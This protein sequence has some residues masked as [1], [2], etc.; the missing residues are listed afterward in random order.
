MQ[1]PGREALLLVGDDGQPQPG[2][3][4]FAQRSLGAGVGA[5]GVGFVVL[6]RA[7]VVEEA[8]DDRRLQ[9]GGQLAPLRCCRARDQRRRA[10]ADHAPHLLAADGWPALFGERALE[11]ERD[12]VGGV[13]QRA[14]EVEQHGLERLLAPACDAGGGRGGGGWAGLHGVPAPTS[15]VA[16]STM[17]ATV[18]PSAS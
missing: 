15:A 3:V 12:V 2:R 4:Q 18:S 17:R 11:R 7:V 6:Q 16:R 1:Q 9:I 14:V 13:E 8:L 10:A 5:G